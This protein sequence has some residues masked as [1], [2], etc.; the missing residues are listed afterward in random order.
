MSQPALQLRVGY[1]LVYEC[2]KPTPMIVTLNIH[3]TRISDLVRPDHMITAPA[4]PIAS[5]RDSYG[6]WCTRIVAPAGRLRLSADAVVNDR[7]EPDVV[8]PWLG[9]HP[10]PELPE[11]TLLF[12]LGSRYCETEPLLELAWQPFES[13]AARLG[14]RPGDLRLR[15]RPHRVRLRAREPDQDRVGGVSEPAR[16]C[17]AT[18]P[19]SRSRSAGA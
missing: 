8:A 14:A 12:L 10:V 6:N 2:P 19:T 18:T 4:I 1:E 15:A 9:Q 17:A 5:Y 3:Y 16:A 7:G 13:I 11:E